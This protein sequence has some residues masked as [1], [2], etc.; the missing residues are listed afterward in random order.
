MD[1]PNNPAPRSGEEFVTWYTECYA[2]DDWQL[3][4]ATGWYAFVDEV[5]VP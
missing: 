5:E 1:N 4:A 3:N 2:A